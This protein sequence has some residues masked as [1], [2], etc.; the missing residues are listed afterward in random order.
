VRMPFGPSLHVLIQEL[1]DHLRPEEPPVQTARAQEGIIGH[2]SEL[3]QLHEGITIEIVSN[4]TVTVPMPGSTA[5][6]L[7]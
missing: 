5:Q 7:T 1:P 3:P 4:P 6:Q 2:L